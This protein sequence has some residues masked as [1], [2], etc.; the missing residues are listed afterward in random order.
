MDYP[1]LPEDDSI[2][3]SFPDIAIRSSTG[4]E[5]E[6]SHDHEDHEISG[7]ASKSLAA[8]STVLG[9]IFAF[10]LILAAII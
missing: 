3:A 1:L 8:P 4:N 7:D 10:L 2:T 5:D 9:T 6:E